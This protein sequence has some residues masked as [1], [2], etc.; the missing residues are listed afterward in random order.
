MFL[1]SPLEMKKYIGNLEP[2]GEA[3]IRWECGALWLSA[4]LDSNPGKSI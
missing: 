4:R 2:V 1:L 3:W